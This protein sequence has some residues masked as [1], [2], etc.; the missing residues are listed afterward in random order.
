MP[1]PHH[2][3]LP[4][5]D[6]ELI[7]EVVTIQHTKRGVQLKQTRTPMTQTSP[8]ETA[9]PSGSCSKSKKRIKPSEV[10]KE[11]QVVE[12]D[13]IIQTYEPGNDFEYHPYDAPKEPQPHANVC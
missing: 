5:S 7:E 13:D 2:V 4:E 9:K 12:D 11:T 3:P 10:E 8:I 6:D 1:C